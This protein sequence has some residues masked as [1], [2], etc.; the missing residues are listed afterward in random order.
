MSAPIL[1]I[2]KTNLP[3]RLKIDASSEGVGG[4]LEQSHGSLETHNGIQ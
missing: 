2:F 1:K 3:K 4:L